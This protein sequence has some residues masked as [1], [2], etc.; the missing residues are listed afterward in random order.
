MDQIE[1]NDNFT[2]VLIIYYMCMVHTCKWYK[3]MHR[4]PVILWFQ[5]NIVTK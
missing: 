2:K 4:N 5:E 3:L 1:K